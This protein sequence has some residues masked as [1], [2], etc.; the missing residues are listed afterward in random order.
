MFPWHKQSPERTSRASVG[1]RKRQTPSRAAYG[2]GRRFNFQ[3]LGRL[4]IGLLALPVLALG[5]SKVQMFDTRY[6][7]TS[8]APGDAITVISD[9]P[10]GTKYSRGFEKKATWCIRNA[11]ENT[12]PTVRIVSSDELRQVAFPDLTPEEIPLGNRSWDQLVEDPAFRERIAS[13]GL[14]Y[15]ITVS[16]SKRRTPQGPEFGIDRWGW[17]VA[18]Q[19]EHSASI[20]AKVVDL[21]R[22]RVA[23]DVSV[24]ATGKSAFA[25]AF[26]YFIFP[27]P[28]GKPSFPEWRACRE[29]GEWAVRF[30]T[31]EKRS[32]EITPVKIEAEEFIPVDWSS[33][34][35]C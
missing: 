16:G 8:L 27:V 1:A 21:M 19:W 30:L 15:L 4:T 31:G 5:C 7:P 34:K 3:A 22:A 10:A 20:N 2:P 14:R 6:S 26:F 32:E 24:D 33:T 29:L 28:L 35:C 11:L 25:V 18:W 12:H 23:G 9:Q 17:G 13:L